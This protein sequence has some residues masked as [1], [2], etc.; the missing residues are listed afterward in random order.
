M[1]L[2]D[3]I[4]I[5]FYV[6]VRGVLGQHTLNDVVERDIRKRVLAPTFEALS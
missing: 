3:L 1:D 4:K 2:H 6:F 5:G